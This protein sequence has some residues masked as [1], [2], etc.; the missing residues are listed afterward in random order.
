MSI[1]DRITELATEGNQ[2]ALALLK[3]AMST[4]SSEGSTKTFAAHWVL[5]GIPVINLKT[6]RARAS[7][8]RSD[9]LAAA[10]AP[11]TR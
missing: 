2:L 6:L 7:S 9:H 10:I 3:N 8:K 1:D 4:C 11:I 5:G